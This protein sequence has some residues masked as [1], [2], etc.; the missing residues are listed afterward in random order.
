MDTIFMKSHTKTTNLK[1]QP[2]HGIKSL[3]YLMDHY[4]FYYQIFKIIL[5]ILSKSM[6][7]LLITLQKRGYVNKIKNRITFKIKTGII[8]NF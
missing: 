1:Y 3:S 7:H 5:I 6:T 8:S 2:R 4:H